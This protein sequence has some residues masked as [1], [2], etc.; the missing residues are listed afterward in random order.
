M[1]EIP[2]LNHDLDPSKKLLF[3]KAVAKCYFNQSQPF[4]G[5]TVRA[6]QFHQDHLTL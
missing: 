3:C 2:M 5:A 4:L 6:Q 1:K